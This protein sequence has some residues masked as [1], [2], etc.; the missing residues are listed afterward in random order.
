MGAGASLNLPQNLQ[1][2]ELMQETYQKIRM[3]F[4]ELDKVGHGL[5]SRNDFY[6]VCETIPGH[7]VSPEEMQQAF[8]YLDRNHNG[9]IEEKEFINW[10]QGLPINEQYPTHQNLF[11][12]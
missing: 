11:Y 12:N 4:K 7:F 2:D 5:I 10:W 3:L 9:S 8:K 1:N 6:E